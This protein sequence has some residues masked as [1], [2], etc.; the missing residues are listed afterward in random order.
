[1]TLGSVA[2]PAVKISNSV[3]LDGN[4]YPSNVI[5]SCSV[6]GGIRGV[7]TVDSTVKLT[8]STLDGQSGY[9]VHVNSTLSASTM[10][11]WI[12]KNLVVSAETPGNVG[13][14]LFGN[15]DDEETDAS[16]LVQNNTIHGWTRGIQ[17]STQFTGST[18][19]KYE[20]AIENNMVSA[21]SVVGI[22]H[23]DYTY[24]RIAW[25]VSEEGFDP[26]A[27]GNNFVYPPLYC[28][29]QESKV[30]EFTLRWDS[31]GAPGNLGAHALIG[32]KPV[33]CAF[34]TLARD[35]NIADGSDV[36]VLHDVFVPEDSTLTIG[37]GSTI[38]F[39]DTDESA[40]GGNGSVPRFLDSALMWS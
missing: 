15:P 23:Q 36:L 35:V 18:T 5:D 17:T 30:D 7:E 34:D 21:S 20:P 8:N 12:E 33:E 39:D 13:L 40:N 25:N 9:G 27:E 29:S 3:Q 24:S 14:F 22:D 31:P 19:P 1:M 4:G 2:S 32:A 37:K 11:A 38:R 28:G 16:A 10:H 26:S 6:S